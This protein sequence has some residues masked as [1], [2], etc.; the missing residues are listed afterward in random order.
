MNTLL[1]LAG[2]PDSL[3]AA[4]LGHTVVVNR[5]AYLAQPRDLAPV[6]NIIGDI[7]RPV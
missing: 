7:F 6:S 2:T 4:W 5:T 1:E 3:R